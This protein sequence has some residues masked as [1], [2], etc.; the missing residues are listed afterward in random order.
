[1]EKTEVHYLTS[2]TAANSS[3]W[4]LYRIFYGSGC[5]MKASNHNVSQ[6]IVTT[7]MNVKLNVSH[8]IK[9]CWLQY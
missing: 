9:K 2:D 8:T 3:D 4:G 1:M 6:I 5:K 7:F